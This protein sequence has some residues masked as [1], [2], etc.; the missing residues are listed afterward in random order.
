MINRERS[1]MLD[2]PLEPVIGLAEGETRWRSM[3][4]YC[5]DAQGESRLAKRH[6]AIYKT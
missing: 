6:P 4:V 2:T 1:G 5:W 3:T